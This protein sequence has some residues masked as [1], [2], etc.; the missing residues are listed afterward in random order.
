MFTN[1]YTID[2]NFHVV[3]NTPYCEE[4]ISCYMNY[5]IGIQ[6]IWKLRFRHRIKEWENVRKNKGI[7]SEYFHIPF[8]EE[9]FSNLRKRIFTLPASIRRQATEVDG[10]DLAG[11]R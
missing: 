3:L 7:S 10:R 1:R 6:L 8:T 11:A 2:I 9:I 4:D 5:D